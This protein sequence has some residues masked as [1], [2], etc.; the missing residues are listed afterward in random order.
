MGT[1]M[2]EGIAKCVSRDLWQLR[3]K[4]ML[5]LRFVGVAVWG[6]AVWRSCGVWQLQ[7]G[8]VALLRSL[9]DYRTFIHYVSAFFNFFTFFAFSSKN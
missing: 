6:L 2:C 3:C 5:E 8:G 4:G 7:G 1:L 9:G